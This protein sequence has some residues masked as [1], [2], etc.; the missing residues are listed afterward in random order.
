MKNKNTSLLVNRIV[1]KIATLIN[2][3]TESG[4]KKESTTKNP[5]RYVKFVKALLVGTAI[6]NIIKRKVASLG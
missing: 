4:I 2:I 1:F 5:F 3:I 6:A